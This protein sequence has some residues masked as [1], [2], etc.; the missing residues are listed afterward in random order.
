MTLLE[1]N[2]IVAFRAVTKAADRKGGVEFDL[3]P[4]CTSAR[5]RSV[6][7]SWASAAARKK[8]DIE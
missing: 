5:A 6:W 3:S 1:E 4:I 8:C 7:P 2:W